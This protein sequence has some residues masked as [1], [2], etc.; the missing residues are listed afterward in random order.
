MIWFYRRSVA[1]TIGHMFASVMNE[2]QCI[3]GVLRGWRSRRDS[4]IESRS[5]RRETFTKAL[6]D[7]HWFP[8]II[9]E[10][11]GPGSK[12]PSPSSSNI[13]SV[14]KKVQNKEGVRRDRGAN[15]C[16]SGPC[17]VHHCSPPSVV[18]RRGCFNLFVLFVLLIEVHFC[19]FSLPFE[20]N[21][22]VA[23]WIFG[24]SCIVLYKSTN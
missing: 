8:S 9:G 20:V 5:F 14:L 6:S 23:G 11:P 10:A 7:Q 19:V 4:L 17:N 2:R 16:I 22:G 13:L 15:I 18:G 24:T 12:W 3:I 21:G 1:F